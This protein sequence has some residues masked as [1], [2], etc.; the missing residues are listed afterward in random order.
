MSNTIKASIIGALIGGAFTIT[1]AF[2]SL[3]SDNS[4]KVLNVVLPEDKIVLNRKEIQEISDDMDAQYAD[5]QKE[6][7]RLKKIINEKDER[8]EEYQIPNS[9]KV[10]TEIKTC[11]NGFV[12]EIMEC[13]GNREKQQVYIKIL[14]TNKKENR[15]LGI[16]GYGN[17]AQA[18]GKA[19]HGVCGGTGGSI[20]CNKYSIHNNQIK[21]DKSLQCDIQINNV[22]PKEVKK[23]DLLHIKYRYSYLLEI[24]IKETLIKNYKNI[25]MKNIE[26]ALESFKNIQELIRFIDQKSGAV[27]VIA[28]LVFTGYIEFLK[29]LDFS[30]SFSFWGIITLISSI[31]TLISLVVVIYISIFQVLKPRLAKNYQKDEYSLFY[32][33]HLSNLGKEKLNNEYKSV[34]EDDMLKYVVDQQFEISKILEQKTD[35]LGLSFNLLFVSIISLIT[36]IISSIQ[37]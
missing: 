34:N 10:N 3:K 27:L 28:G 23:I 15:R 36:F 2:I 19:I 7:Q 6:I 13:V 12:F 17:Y 1:A 30:N 20:T 32:F 8:F 22:L 9:P 25:N 16:G 26:F 29:D 4:E 31:A 24:M 11:S 5:C 33:E 21:T 14:A 35:K 18:N 37:L